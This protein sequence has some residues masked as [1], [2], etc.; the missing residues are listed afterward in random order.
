MKNI[1][2]T[3]WLTDFMKQ[4]VRPGDL[5][6]DATMGNGNDTLT[7][8]SLCME[9]GQVLA[10]DIQEQALSRT[11]QLLEEKSPF[12]NYRLILDSHEHLELYAQPETVS[13]IVFNFGYLPGSDHRLSTQ[14]ESSLTA[15]GAALRLLKR[16][17]LLCLCLYSGKDTGFEEREAILRWLKG[18]DPRQY[19]VICCEYY[20]RANHPPLPVLVI[21][22]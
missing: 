5:C 2:I 8:S 19:L 9:T 14:T 10:F 13:C 18:L 11:R 20:N 1:Q 21:K 4:Q 12:R 7:L 15:L 17:G 6:I 16:E 22:L 3:Q